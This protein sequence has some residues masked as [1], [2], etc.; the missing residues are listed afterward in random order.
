[1]SWKEKGQSFSTC[2]L[3][4]FASESLTVEA[5]FLYL[6]NT[7]L[8]VGDLKFLGDGIY[9]LR[10]IGLLPILFRRYIW[11]DFSRIRFLVDFKLFRAYVVVISIS[12]SK[13]VY[14]NVGDT[15]CLDYRL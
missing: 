6:L 3:S 4:C 9:D 13:S 10:S 7:D 1:M 15:L 8:F 12:A 14:D 11:A 5:V 2:I